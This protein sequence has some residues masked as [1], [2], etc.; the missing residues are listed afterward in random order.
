MSRHDVLAHSVL[1]KKFGTQCSFAV[2][3]AMTTLAG[4]WAMRKEPDLGKNG[5]RVPVRMSVSQV[6]VWA[7]ETPAGGW[8]I[9]GIKMLNVFRVLKASTDQN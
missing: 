9:P 3:T 7:P 6:V 2:K 4:H 8:R 5:P 1:W